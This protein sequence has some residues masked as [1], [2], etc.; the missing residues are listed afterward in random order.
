[1]AS[2]RQVLTG[3]AEHLQA[4]ALLVCNSQ[5]QPTSHSLPLVLQ[6]QG[7]EQRSTSCIFHA[8]IENNSV[9]AGHIQNW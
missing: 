1:M 7:P 3:C 9:M 5:G 2:A 6:Q 4:V 8:D